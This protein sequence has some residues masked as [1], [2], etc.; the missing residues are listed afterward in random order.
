MAELADATDSK[1]VSF[2]SEGSTPSL[3][4]MQDFVGRL[5]EPFNLR[6]SFVDSPYEPLFRAKIRFRGRESLGCG[7]IR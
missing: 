2:G 3:G 4:T 6:V 5:I 1:S 7:G